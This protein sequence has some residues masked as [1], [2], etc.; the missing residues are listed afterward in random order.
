MS[1]PVRLEPVFLEKPWG[2]T[3]TAPW[4]PDAEGKVGEVWFQAKPPLPILIKFLFTSESLS[5]QVHPPDRPGAAGKTEMWHVLRAASGAR[6]GLGFRERVEREA[7]RGAA[8]SGEIVNLMQWFPVSAGDT[9]LV[10]AG[11]VHALGAGLALCEIQQNSD[12]TYRLYDYGRARQ[13]H[14]T[15]G[16]EVADPAP[17]PGRSSPVE[18]ESGRMLLARCPYFAT[19]LLDL[20]GSIDFAPDPEGFSLLTAIEGCGQIGAQSFREG[21]VWLIPAGAQRFCLRPGGH[22][23]LLRSRVPRD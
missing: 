17:H 22:A 6:I 11:V 10:P 9:Y 8:R 23:R 21:E 12:V 13:L 20:T 2:S 14:L 19:E 3:A 15:E 4:F 18:I 7:L 1:L 5:V 16:L